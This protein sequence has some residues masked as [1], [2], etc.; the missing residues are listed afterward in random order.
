ML[1]TEEIFA[2]YHQRGGDELLH[3]AFKEFASETLPFKRF[4]PNAACHYTM[5][6]GFFL[7]ETFKEGGPHR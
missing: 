5:L 1:S 4:T 7:Y 2:G 3:R 6:L